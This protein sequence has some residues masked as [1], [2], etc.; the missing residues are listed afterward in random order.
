L[1]KEEEES[2]GKTVAIDF[3]IKDNMTLS[4]G[5]KINFKLPETKRLKRLQRHLSRKENGSKNREK[6]RQKVAKEYERINNR[7]QDAINK[8]FSFLKL[9]NSLREKLR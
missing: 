1:P 6:A 4:N 9:Y 3:G 5:M 8:I 7:K 2:L